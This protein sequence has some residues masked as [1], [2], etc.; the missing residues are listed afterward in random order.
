MSSDSIPIDLDNHV[1]ANPAALAADEP[2]EVRV[3]YVNNGDDK[4]CA[5][6]CT[7]ACVSK[8]AKHWHCPHCWGAQYKPANM[9]EHIKICIQETKL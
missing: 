7:H 9:R 5:C 6:H 3:P 2:A 1:P 8:Q 4:G